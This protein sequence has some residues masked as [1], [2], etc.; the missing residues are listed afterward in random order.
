MR[1]VTFRVVLLLAIAVCGFTHTRAQIV[2]DPSRIEVRV[3]FVTIDRLDLGKAIVDWTK[4]GKPLRLDDATPAER[5]QML[6][7][8]LLALER[9]IRHE[10]ETYG[11]NIRPS[12]YHFFLERV[13]KHGPTDAT[14]REALSETTTIFWQPR[15]AESAGAGAGAGA[16][17]GAEDPPKRHFIIRFFRFFKPSW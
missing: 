2:S 17:A 10:K 12:Q 6:D 13:R 9:R 7:V 11:K 8:L 1:A 15:A 4:G 16:A 5:Q 14:F 3:G